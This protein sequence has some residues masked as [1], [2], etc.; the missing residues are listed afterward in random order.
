ML[1]FIEL[2]PLLDRKFYVGIFA[3]ENDLGN[4]NGPFLTELVAAWAYTGVMF[5]RLNQQ[6][7]DELITPLGTQI[8]D[9]TK[10][11]Q[12]LIDLHLP[13]LANQ[14]IT[15][16]KKGDAITDNVNSS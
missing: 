6:N 3:E 2:S 16:R 11:L 14:D 12:D 7:W 1:N 5:N 8:V 15:M 10:Y 4:V 13:K 9:N